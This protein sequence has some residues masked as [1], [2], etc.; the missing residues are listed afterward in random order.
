MAETAMQLEDRNTHPFQLDTAAAALRF[1]LVRHRPAVHAGN[2]CLFRFQLL[3]AGYRG[4][5][6]RHHAKGARQATDRVDHEGKLVGSR[7]KMSSDEKVLFRKE[8]PHP[9]VRVVPTNDLQPRMP[10]EGAGHQLPPLIGI[11][12]PRYCVAGDGG[13][14][15]LA[16]PNKLLFVLCGANL[17]HAGPSQKQPSLFD[18]FEVASMLLQLFPARSVDQQMQ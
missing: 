5:F 4:R 6:A 9:R 2:S 15:E 11:H 12:S 3:E 14:N 8:N 13:A 7:K 18:L 1:F 17:F 10:P 16:D